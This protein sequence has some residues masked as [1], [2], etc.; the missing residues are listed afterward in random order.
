MNLIHDIAFYYSQKDGKST[1]ERNALYEMLVK[2]LEDALNK[3]E[4]KSS[5]S[6]FLATV[7]VNTLTTYRTNTNTT[8]SKVDNSIVDWDATQDVG[9]EVDYDKILDEKSITES[10]SEILTSSDITYDEYYVICATFGI[11][12]ERQTQTEIIKESSFSPSTQRTLLKS[13][14]AKLK[15]LAIIKELY[16]GL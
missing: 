4:Q 11:G 16:K 8:R 5:L 2:K 7:A 13:A 12:R 15:E 3:W 9:F 1:V 6:T 10:I 14:F